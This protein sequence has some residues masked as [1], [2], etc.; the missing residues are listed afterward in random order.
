MR[1]HAAKSAPT[2]CV[3]STMTKN[4]TPTVFPGMSECS[5]KWAVEAVWEGRRSFTAFRMTMGVSLLYLLGTRLVP[6]F[7]ACDLPLLSL[8]ES[9]NGG[10]QVFFLSAAR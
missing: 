5:T 3:S 9:G 6:F 2:V 4:H 1:V 8:L 10:N 7:P